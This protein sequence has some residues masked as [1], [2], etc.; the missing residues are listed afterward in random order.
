[1]HFQRTVNDKFWGEH[2]PANLSG[3][4]F[5]EVLRGG[6]DLAVV[7]GHIGFNEMNLRW[8]EF[9]G[10]YPVLANVHDP[11]TSFEA[12]PILVEGDQ[13]IWFVSEEQSHGMTDQRLVEVFT[14]ILEWCKAKSI[15]SVITNG[16]ADVD[17]TGVTAHNRMSDDRRARFLRDFLGQHESDELRFTLISLNDVFIRRE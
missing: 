15:R 8:R 2:M 1:M 16:I 6:Y 9:H 14:G 7:F 3:D 4:I 10:R 11:F 13:W 12:Q 17:H 5:N